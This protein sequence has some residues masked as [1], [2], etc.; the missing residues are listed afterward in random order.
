MSPVKSVSSRFLPTPG[1][2]GRRVHPADVFGY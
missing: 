1:A 2:P